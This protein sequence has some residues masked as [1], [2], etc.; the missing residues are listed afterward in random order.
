MTF[1]LFSC[2]MTTSTNYFLSVFQKNA[3]DFEKLG[4]P[5]HTFSDRY[6]HLQI[7]QWGNYR[8]ERS[9]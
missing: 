9:F 4:D 2:Y 3:Q 8:K 5:E 6:Q 1:S 7:L